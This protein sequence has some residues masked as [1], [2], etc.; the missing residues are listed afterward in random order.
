MNLSSIVKTGVVVSLTV[1]TLVFTVLA[2]G[3]PGEYLLSSRWRDLF[4]PYSP[5]TNPSF[6]ADEE[7]VAL[8]LAYSPVLQGE[9][10]LYEA[11]VV[12]PV[13]FTEQA[14]GFTMLGEND[15]AIAGNGIDPAGRIVQTGVSLKNSNSFF[16]ATYALKPF[17]R[18]IKNLSLGANLTAAYQS[19]FGSP[20]RGLG[21][22]IGTSYKMK[23]GG[24]WGSH[25]LG[26][27]TLNLIAPSMAN[28][29]IPALG[30]NG[31][32]SRGLKLSW[33][34]LMFQE[35]VT[36]GMDFNLKD[37]LA[38]KEEFGN[39]S[40]NFFNKL[41]KSD[42]ALSM[43]GGYEV[44]R[45][46]SLYGQLG[47]D[48]HVIDY[49]G[50]A[51]GMNLAAYSKRTKISTIYQYNLNPENLGSGYLTPSSHTVYLMAKMG[52]I[53]REERRAL[54][55]P[56]E[57]YNKARALFL[58]QR[59][60]DAYVVFCELKN[61][62]P[63]FPRNDWVTFLMGRCFEE[64]DM[65][66]GALSQFDITSGTYPG[67]S[68]IPHSDLAAMRV[69]YRDEQDGMVASKYEVLSQ[70]GIPDSIRYN[71]AY[72]YGE[73][74]F[75]RGDLDQAMVV[76]SVIPPE[77]EDY[78]FAQY[79]LA[80]INAQLYPQSPSRTILNLK[81][82]IDS[83]AQTTAQKEM[84]NKALVY[85]GY[86]SYENGDLSQAVTSFR[87]V[88]P[89]SY[90]Y[91]ESLRGLGWSAMRASQWKDCIAAGEQ[92]AAVSK[93]PVLR[94]EGLLLQGLGYYSLED[95]VSA[96][97]KTAEGD[98]LVNSITPPMHDS[99][100]AAKEVYLRDRD[101][102]DELSLKLAEVG[103]V[104]DSL[105]PAGVLDS[106]RQVQKGTYTKLASFL[107]YADEF[108]RSV[109]LSSYHESAAAD[110]HYA[111]ARLKTII[112]KQGLSTSNVAKKMSDIDKQ[113]EETKK[114]MEQLESKTQTAE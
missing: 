54:L 45:G 1:S 58:K 56:N 48:S 62:Y 111:A 49:W 97:N 74:R 63:Q 13:G 89:S 18:G 53:T 11:G 90:Y 92:L 83:P 68:V 37:Y 19:N 40:G 43:R 16:L 5:L 51:M 28:T 32:L 46:I 47:F 76:L 66:K 86:F 110:L 108:S 114:Q 10:T 77:H 109:K 69:F 12:V 73:S 71:A 35:K 93:R 64:L 106:L 105:R 85:L 55:E 27:S 24:N 36:G 112:A 7:H 98:D 95:F 91:E 3:L 87:K 104:T 52:K 79:T 38:A 102:Y 33:H 78:V 50:L 21:L 96:Y 72:L 42:W 4:G 94:C 30:N 6:I 57:L 39:T 67:S 15:G 65:R 14:L 29:W 26:V 88:S 81:N 103:A 44:F 34:A 60:W 59:Y 41:G 9:F 75:R 8:R 2:D 70:P 84:V 17:T 25:F 113:M 80:V 100:Q 61:N 101:S 22:D 20:R 107:I 31:E 99:L 23:L 82:C